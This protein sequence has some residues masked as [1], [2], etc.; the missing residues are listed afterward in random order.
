[1][2]AKGWFWK[3]YHLAELT[4]ELVYN[5]S[6]QRKKRKPYNVSNIYNIALN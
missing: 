6:R 2:D 3:A 5:T 1:M 4:H